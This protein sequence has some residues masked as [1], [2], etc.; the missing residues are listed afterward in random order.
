M[1]SV[2]V[3][4]GGGGMTWTFTHPDY[5]VGCGGFE[6]PMQV[7]GKTYLYV[8]NRILKRHEYYVFEDDRFIHD[9]DVPWH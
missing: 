6:E 1:G 3:G 9:S 8:W 4:M 7:H 5:K 2:G